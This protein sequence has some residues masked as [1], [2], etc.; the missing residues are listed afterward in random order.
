MSLYFEGI[1]I[2]NFKAQPPN[3]RHNVF[4]VLGKVFNTAVELVKFF[5]ALG[6]FG[7]TGIGVQ[8]L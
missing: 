2:I 1:L 3:L 6:T 4:M 8:F 5:E 7:L